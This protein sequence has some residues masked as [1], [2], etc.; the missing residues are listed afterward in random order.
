MFLCSYITYG[1]T[2]DIGPDGSRHPLNLCA[3]HVFVHADPICWLVSSAGTATC[4]VC[5]TICV[6]GAVI[7]GFLMGDGVIHD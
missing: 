5:S 7:Q 1:K 4:H 3:V 2:K 6:R